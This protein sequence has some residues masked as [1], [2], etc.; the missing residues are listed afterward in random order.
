MFF[1]LFSGVR[2][3]A[4]AFLIKNTNCDVTSISRFVFFLTS[5]KMS[6]RRAK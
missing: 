6:M 4:L 2:F 3:A 1:L 5:G